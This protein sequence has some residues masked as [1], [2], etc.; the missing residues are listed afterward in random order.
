MYFR[1]VELSF[2]AT[3]MALLAY[4]MQIYYDF[5]GYSDMAIGLGKMF[6]FNFLENFN[7][8]L[9]LYFLHYFADCL[10]RVHN[11]LENC[12]HHAV[13]EAVNVIILGKKKTVYV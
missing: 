5:S 13:V 8:F 7:N 6:G 2:L 11:T 3:V 1:E 4:T 10:F 9:H 12:A